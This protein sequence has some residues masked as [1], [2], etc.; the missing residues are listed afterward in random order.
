MGVFDAAKDALT[1]NKAKVQQGLDAAV[2]QARKITPPQH[3][4]KLDK[5]ANAARSAVDK[6]EDGPG[7]SGTDPGEA[8]AGDTGG[9]DG[10]ASP[11]G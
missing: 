8:G 5:A 3:A 4:S 9:A 1:K 10:P 6:L 7:T 2:E 11:T